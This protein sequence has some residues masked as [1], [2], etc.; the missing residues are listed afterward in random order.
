[1][2]YPIP[3]LDMIAACFIILGLPVIGIVLALVQGNM[4]WL[5]L[6]LPLFVFQEGG[7]VLIIIILFVVSL[8]MGI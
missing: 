2:R 6:T 4:W 8:L 1:M 3:R 7:L 5:T